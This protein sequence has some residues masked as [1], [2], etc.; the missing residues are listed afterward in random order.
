MP[1][2]GASRIRSLNSARLR[3]ILKR[4]VIPDILLKPT[5]RSHASD[6]PRACA[7]VPVDPDLPSSKIS[8]SMRRGALGNAQISGRNTHSQRQLLFISRATRLESSRLVTAPLAPSTCCSRSRQCIG[9]RRFAETEM[10]PFRCS[11][12]IV[13]SRLRRRR[14]RLRRCTLRLCEISIAATVCQRG[15]RIARPC[16][17]RCS[18]DWTVT[19]GVLST[20]LADGV[21]EPH[22]LLDDLRCDCLLAMRQLRWTMRSTSQQS[23]RTQRSGVTDA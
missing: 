6:E 1:N 7:P 21:M 22:R 5:S 20:G 16:L 2:L 18:R 15:A 11:G 13:A 17:T 3:R 19:L 10:A 8:S 14:G 12:E 23:S 4:S 9:T